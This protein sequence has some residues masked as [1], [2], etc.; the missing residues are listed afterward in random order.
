M[1]TKNINTNELPDG[2]FNK[3]RAVGVN[4]VANTVYKPIDAFSL[5]D[6]VFLH[7]VSRNQVIKEL[8]NR[9]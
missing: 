5:T 8:T 3:L 2:F 7:E 1:S 9:W 4:W 6:K